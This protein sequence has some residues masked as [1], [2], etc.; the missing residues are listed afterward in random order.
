MQ[1]TRLPVLLCGLLV[2]GCASDLARVSSPAIG[3]APSEIQIDD[4]S[5]GWAET[6][7]SAQCRGQAFHCAG[8]SIAS[9]SPDRDSLPARSAAP[10][11]QQP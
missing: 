2:C 1:P 6:S 7:W 10:T 11:E 5:I 9:C 4:I 8:E 3:C